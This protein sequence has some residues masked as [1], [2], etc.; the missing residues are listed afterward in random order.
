MAPKLAALQ[1]GIYLNAKL[2]K[3]VSEIYEKRHSLNLDAESLRLVEYDYQQFVLAGANLS[4][5]D[6]AQLK[7]L[8]E[9]EANLTTAF[10]S[11]LLAATKD[12]AFVSKDKSALAGLTDAEVAAAADA[13]KGRKVEG[14]VLP[15]QNTTQQPDLQSLA[16]RDHASSDF[17]EFM[18]SGRAW[19]RQRYSGYHCPPGTVARAES[20]A[21]RLPELRGLEADRPDGQ[22]TGGGAEIHGR[23]GAGLNRQG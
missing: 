4:D 10:I 21:A 22:D 17:Q 12:A 1:D 18:E 8:N 13:A 14:Y 23:T 7:K 19:R 9:E 3:R 6:K 20:Q 11:K 2:F 15:M 16:N 5:A